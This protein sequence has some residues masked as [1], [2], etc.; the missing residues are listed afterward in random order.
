VITA[1]TLIVFV[2]L[3]ILTIAA[4]L[5]VSFRHTGNVFLYIL[6]GA[7]LLLLIFLVQR[8]GNKKPRGLL[9]IIKSTINLI[10]LLW[11]KA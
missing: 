1:R 9:G 10:D 3:V 11:Q 5:Y 2:G 6:S 8:I 4:S 7:A